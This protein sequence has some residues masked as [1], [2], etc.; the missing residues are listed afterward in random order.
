MNS[1]RRAAVYILWALKETS[2]RQWLTRRQKTIT[3]GGGL[4]AEDKVEGQSWQRGSIFRV[5]E[6]PKRTKKQGV[7]EM[8]LGYVMF[9][10]L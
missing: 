1:W 2:Q 7:R 10:N 9:F 8:V 3:G 4:M 6:K 5:E